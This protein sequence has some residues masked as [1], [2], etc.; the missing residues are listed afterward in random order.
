MSALFN[1][2]KFLAVLGALLA[3][4]TALWRRKDRVQ[5]LWVSLGGTE[6]VVTT[7]SR[8]LETAS[9]VRDVV[10]RFANLKK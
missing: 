9:P 7:T 6:G 1:A 8:L 10:S 3:A 5:Q 4:G 2:F